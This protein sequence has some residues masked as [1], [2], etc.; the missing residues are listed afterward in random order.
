[1]AG[2]RSALLREGQATASPSRVRRGALVAASVSALLAVGLVAAAASQAARTR[3]AS[4][5]ALLEA[6]S[7]GGS[8]A[9]AREPVRYYY[10]PASEAQALISQ[11]QLSAAPGDTPPHYSVYNTGAASATRKASRTALNPEPDLG[12]WGTARNGLDPQ[13][14]CTVPN[15]VAL[16]NFVQPEWEKCK[17]NPNYIEPNAPA[18][19]T[20]ASD[21]T[22]AADG[23]AGEEAPAE[24]SAPSPAGW[25]YKEVQ[26]HDVTAADIARARQF[27]AQ[28][29]R[30]VKH[31]LLSGPSAVQQME[32][33]FGGSS[34]RRLLAHV[35]TQQLANWDT[36]PVLDPSAPTMKQCMDVALGELCKM[37]ASCDDP[38]CDNYYNETEVEGLCGMCEMRIGDKDKGCFASHGH[39][40]TA[41]GTVPVG[42]LRLG[43]WV[44]SVADGQVAWARVL[45]LHDHQEVAATLA[46]TVDALKGGGHR[47]MELTAPHLIHVRR[48]GGRSALVPARNIKVGDLVYAVEDGVVGERAVRAVEASRAKV[49]YVVT[50]NDLLVVDGVVASVYSTGAG[51]WETL[52]FHLLHRLLP[53]VF[54]LRYCVVPVCCSLVSVAPRVCACVRTPTCTAS[55]TAY[56]AHAIRHKCHTSSIMHLVS[57]TVLVDHA[58][59]TIHLVCSTIHLVCSI[60]HVVRS[61]PLVPYKQQV[62]RSMHLVSNI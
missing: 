42:D 1:M 2:E 8:S 14:K 47:R 25:L 27:K 7:A 40:S 17:E 3:E 11:Q 61:S 28:A 23:E 30:F 59:R 29:Q 6:L 13:W 60:I 20:N 35:N 31:K 4:R 44:E 48:P 12:A 33:Y 43:D 18:N 38:V 24:E 53:G 16:Y 50:E 52:P 55:D 15:L 58:F 26:G 41:R 49:R 37:L 62:F 22:A 45:F 10:V 9:G 32:S 34:S 21:A 56:L 5:A 36:A 51:R 46:L 57:G 54:G 39:V 19:A